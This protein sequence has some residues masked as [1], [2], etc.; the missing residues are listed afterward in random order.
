MTFT[1]LH[2]THGVLFEQAWGLYLRSFPPQERRQLRVQRRVMAQN[3]LYHV[4]VIT[5]DA[6]VAGAASVA[7]RFVGILFW[8]GFDDVRYVEHLATVSEV[9]GQGMGARI[10]SGFI[11]RSSVPVILEVELPDDEMSRRRVG[12]YRRAGF[13]LS[14]RHYTHPSYKR[15]GAPVPLALMTHGASMPHGGSGLSN[16]IIEHFLFHHNTIF[17]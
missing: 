7:G 15:G 11:A 5:E 4:E 8:W 17:G 14:D 12:F 10:L 3:E 6:A 1:R 9:R 2:N 16:T 13:V